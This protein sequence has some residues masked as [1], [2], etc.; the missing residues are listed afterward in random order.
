MTLDEVHIRLALPSDLEE[1]YRL[2]LL[3][4][5][6]PF[7]PTSS[8]FQ[9]LVLGHEALSLLAL[10]SGQLAGFVV[11]N[12]SWQIDK[13]CYIATLDVHPAFRRLGIAQ[14]LLST[15][16]E[17][18]VNAGILSIWLHVY[19]RNW[20][21]MRLYEGLGYRRVRRQPGFYGGSRDAWL[22]VKPLSGTFEPSWMR[23]SSE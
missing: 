19:T 1:M 10:S 3:C 23:D 17:K 8:A 20:K 2:D 7:Q 11:V 9:E 18:M 12:R 13:A 14:L 6:E 15:A 4:F 16:E 21:A 5:R 22:Y